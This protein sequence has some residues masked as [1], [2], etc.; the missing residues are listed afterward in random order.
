[1]KTNMIKTVIALVVAS[2]TSAYAAVTGAAGE[3]S[4]PLVWLF[5]GFCALIVMLQAVP[6]VILFI[7]M[8]RGLFS[9]SEKKVVVPNA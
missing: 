9:A 1:M 6:A 3:G 4:G 8:V 7:S 2:A 5:I